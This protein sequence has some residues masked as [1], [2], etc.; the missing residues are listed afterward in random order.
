MVVQTQQEVQITLEMERS[1]AQV[2]EVEVLTEHRTELTEEM[3]KSLFV[4]FL[5]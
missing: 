2:P 3:E 5:E 4:L 1:P